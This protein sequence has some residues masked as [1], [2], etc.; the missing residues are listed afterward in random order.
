MSSVFNLR[1]G[2][3]KKTYT[4]SNTDIQNAILKYRDHQHNPAI[5]R[6]APFLIETDFLPNFHKKIKALAAKPLK[7][8]PSDEENARTRRQEE[9][10]ARTR[11]QEEEN[12][13]TRTRRQEEENART[14][15]QEEENARTRRQE[16]ENARTRR[17]KGN[18]ET[19]IE[20]S[21]VE[22]LKS[23]INSDNKLVDLI[24]EYEKIKKTNIKFNAKIIKMIPNFNLKKLIN[25]PKD[26]NLEAKVFEMLPPDLLKVLMGI[27]QL[28]CDNVKNGSIST[29]TAQKIKEAVNKAIKDPNFL[30]SHGLIKNTN[31][32]QRINQAVEAAMQ[33]ETE[34]Q[35]RGWVKNSN[36]QPKINRAVEEA[37]NPY[38][39]IGS[40]LDDLKDEIISKKNNKKLDYDKVNDLVTQLVTIVE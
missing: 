30:T 24:K 20:E 31:I 7:E 16:E 6:Q 29:N 33:N 23:L 25:L 19:E 15:R 21:S 13:R 5:W 36:T 18:N 17:Q 34:L 38:L 28:I 1:K 14:R 4:F 8:T 9:E 35:R 3:Q 2:S 26:K 12:A 40:L 32:P 11:R 37:L 10:N 39:T 27:Y 22:N